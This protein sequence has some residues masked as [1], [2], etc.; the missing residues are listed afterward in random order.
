MFSDNAKNHSW[1][2]YEDT[3]STSTTSSSPSYKKLTFDDS[4]GRAKNASSEALDAVEEN[5]KSIITGIDKDSKLS[6]AD[7][8]ALKKFIQEFSSYRLRDGNKI[9]DYTKQ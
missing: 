8:A 7:K 6:D 2:Q 4:S 5:L 3:T 9:T 1:D